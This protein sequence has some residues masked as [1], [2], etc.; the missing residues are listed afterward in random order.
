MIKRFVA[1]QAPDE[2][3]FARSDADAAIIDTAIAAAH[4]AAVKSGGK[5]PA[6]L[7]FLSSML[8]SYR[9][10]KETRHAE[11]MVGSYNTAIEATNW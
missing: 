10:F 2:S 6:E 1:S 5:D 7:H 8:G 11:Q 4:A 3:L 9:T